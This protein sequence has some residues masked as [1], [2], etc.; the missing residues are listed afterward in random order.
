MTGLAE[1]PLGQPGP[2][3]LEASWQ[4]WPSVSVV[5]PT[6]DR[7]ELLRRAITAIAGQEYPGRVDCI[8]TFDRT[9]VDGSLEDGWALPVQALANHRSAGLAGARN[10]GILRATGDLVAFCDDDDEWLDGKLAAQVEALQAN[11]WADVA[12]TGITVEYEGRSTPRVPDSGRVTFRDLLRSRRVDAHPSTF[13][14]RRQALL[15]T[16]GLVDEDLPGSYAEDYE[17]LLR[18]ARKSAIVAVPRPLVRVLWHRSSFF[19][20]RWEVVIPALTYLLERYP[21]F[22]AEP[23]GLARLCGQIAFAHAALGQREPARQW[24]ARCLASN[25]TEGR[26]FLALAVS[27]GVVP[28]GAVTRVANWFGR[29]I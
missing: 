17:L 18:A 25:P 22:E 13:L 7:P 2:V 26:A 16:I 27:Y 19:T 15:D 24:A 3:P 12:T 6:R 14:F 21:E 23:R 5:I 8:V 10:T 28:A 20:R 1:A 11:P 9:E 29:G 4:A